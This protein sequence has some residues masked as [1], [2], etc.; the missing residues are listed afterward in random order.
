[1]DQW[2]TIRQWWHGSLV[3]IPAD[4]VGPHASAATRKFLTE[5]GLPT[6]NV[7]E[8]NFYHDERLLTPIVR[9]SVTYFTFGDDTGTVPFVIE[10]G[11]DA[12][13]TL[14]PDSPTPFAF[15]NST[16]ADFIYC[17]GLFSDRLPQM[18]ETSVGEREPLVDEVRDLVGARD[19]EALDCAGLSWW[20]LIFE[21]IEEGQ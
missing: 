2:D 20:E 7:F 21:K 15:V 13:Q 9:G 19:S 6:D 8:L 1:M 12:V 10:V 14:Q 5:A 11:Q 4:L 3:P 16:L 17:Y 18:V